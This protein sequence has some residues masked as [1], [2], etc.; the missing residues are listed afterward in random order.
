VVWF[1]VWIVWNSGEIHGLRAFDRFP[2]SALTTIISLEAIFL[3][4]ILLMSQ[5]RAGQRSEERSHLDLQINLLA[6]LEATKSL[7]M[8]RAICQKLG[9]PEGDDPELEELLERIEPEALAQEIDHQRPETEP[10]PPVS[11]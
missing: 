1:L 6:E 4:L 10:P 8:L 5:N 9:L 11:A 7:L 3:T 2:Y